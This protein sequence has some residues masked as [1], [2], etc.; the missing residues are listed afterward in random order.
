[1]RK[2]SCLETV[3]AKEVL[4]DLVASSSVVVKVQT[5]T[6]VG[7]N[8]GLEGGRG[9]ESSLDTSGN[10]GGSDVLGHAVAV[11]AAEGN[12]VLTIDNESGSSEGRHLGCVANGQDLT[13]SNGLLSLL[14]LNSE[15]NIE[16]VG[17]EE[18]VL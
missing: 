14:T 8:V 18:S 15:A 16:L 13:S 2:R 9:R 4:D 17:E 3:A 1:M 11:A 5:V 10:V 12:I 7:L 6:C